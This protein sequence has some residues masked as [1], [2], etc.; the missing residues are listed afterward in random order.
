[1][2]SPDGTKVVFYSRASNL[3]TDDT[4]NASDIFIKD[5]VTGAIERISTDAVG[6]QGNSG[7]FRPAFSPDGTKVAFS[8]DASNLMSGDTNGHS[9]IFIVELADA[10]VSPPPVSAW[11]IMPE[12]VRVGETD[13]TVAFTVSRS[14]STLVQIVYVSTVENQGAVNEDDYVSKVNEPLVFVAGE[15]E[16]TV[17]IEILDDDIP[18]DSETFGLVVKTALGEMLA[19]ATFTILD[20]DVSPE[21]LNV[22]IGTTGNDRLDGTDGDDI[23]LGLAG[24]DRLEGRDGNDIIFGGRGN[25][26]LFGGPGDDILVGGPGNDQLDGGPGLDVAIFAGDYADFRITK[27]G[28]RVQVQDRVGSEGKDT[29][30]AV[31]ILQFNNGF[32]DLGDNSFN[33][34]YANARVAALMTRPGFT[35]DPDPLVIDHDD[36]WL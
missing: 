31:E 8:S 16:K 19:S 22:I 20:N 6:G 17:S 14:D 26:R 15:Y 28:P 1:V 2:F 18:E 29:L 32:L 33:E 11:S 34:G 10:W 13:G 24:D 36:Y 5:L 30:T 3:V 9:D 35:T 4:N 7:S 21:P 23:I 27:A 25:D 12:S